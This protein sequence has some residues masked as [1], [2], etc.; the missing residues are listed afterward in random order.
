MMK[1][2]AGRLVAFCL[3]PMIMGSMPQCREEDFLY[4]PT[5]KG[6]RELVFK[7]IR[8]RMSKNAPKYDCEL[9]DAA[10]IKFD[11]PNYDFDEDE[12]DDDDEEDDHGEVLDITPIAAM[13]YIEE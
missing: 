2:L 8:G 4:K 5:D 6:I 10:H 13:K 11:F 1:F 7:E 9:E 12:D 3:F